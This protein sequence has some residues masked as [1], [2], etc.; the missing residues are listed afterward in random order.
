M[1]ARDFLR[2]VQY[3]Y[4]DNVMVL[5]DKQEKGWDNIESI[6]VTDTAIEIEPTGPAAYRFAYKCPFCGGDAHQVDKTD[7]FRGKQKFYECC[8]C[9]ATLSLDWSENGR[10]QKTALLYGK[11]HMW[12]ERF[13]ALS[14]IKC[15]NA[16]GDDVDKDD[17]DYY[18]YCVT[19][20]TISMEY[21]VTAALNSARAPRKVIFCVLQTDVFRWDE[22]DEMI[23]PGDKQNFT[24]E[25]IK[26]LQ[27]VTE[28]IKDTDGIVFENFRDM[29]EYVNLH[30]YKE[31]NEA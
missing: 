10:R 13:K 4:I 9:H 16:V 12:Q 14:N 19:P 21:L 30:R 15:V 2:R 18:V 29:V 25:E 11:Y 5:M 28:M 23:F 1:T 24:Q 3:N 6:K 20:S 31:R 27:R 7:E 8:K 17:F 26:D 22:N